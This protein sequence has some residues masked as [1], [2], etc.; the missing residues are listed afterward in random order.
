MKTQFDLF[1]QFD[2]RQLK[3]T[4]IKYFWQQTNPQRVDEN[5]S[6]TVDN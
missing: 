6:N 3:E 5:E 4:F 2:L 1:S